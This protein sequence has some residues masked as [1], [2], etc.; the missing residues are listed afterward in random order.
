MYTVLQVKTINSSKYEAE[1]N[2]ISFEQRVPSTFQTNKTQGIAV[3]G[4][5]VGGETDI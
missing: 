2:D 5:V 3:S 4:I 1:H